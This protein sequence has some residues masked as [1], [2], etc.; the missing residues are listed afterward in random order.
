M[1]L[2]RF[3]TAK[4]T[5]SKLLIQTDFYHKLEILPLF[6]VWI[7]FTFTGRLFLGMG[8]G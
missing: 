5:S 8:L 3:F 2:F 7:V 4:I 1:V 6:N